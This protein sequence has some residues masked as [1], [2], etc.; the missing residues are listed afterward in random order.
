MLIICPKCSKSFEVNSEL[1]PSKGRL[2]QCGS[3]ENKW[4]YNKIN[5]EVESKIFLEKKPK[6]IKKEISKKSVDI[7]SEINLK[8]PVK[9]TFKFPKKETINIESSKKINYFKMLLVLILTIISF[10]IIID[11]FKLQISS[12]YPD[13]NV[14]LQNLYESLKDIKLFLIDLVK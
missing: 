11:T 8:K 13:I 14:I 12:I 9:K 6:K 10:V 2:V 3:C 4:F 5:N 7:P 1:I